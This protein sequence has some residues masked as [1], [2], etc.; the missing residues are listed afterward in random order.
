MKIIL[1]HLTKSKNMRT[2]YGVLLLF[3]IQIVSIQ[4]Q[5]KIDYREFTLDNGLHVILHKDNTTPIVSTVVLYH[6]GSKNENPERTGFAHFFE[7]LMFEGSENIPRG[8][9]FEIIESE[10]GTL[11]AYTSNDITLYYEV[12]PSNKLE[13]ALY[14][15]SERMLHLKVDTIGVNTQRDVI[16]EEMKQVMEEQPYMS[17]LRELPE[18]MYP[19]HPYQWPVIGAAEHLDASTL[20]E[21]MNFYKTY[22]V[23]NNAILCVAGDIDYDHAEKMVR[24]YFEEIPKGT[25]ELYRPNV[26]MQKPQEEIRDIVYDNIQLPALFQGYQMPP[27]THPDSYALNLLS[28]YL[29]GGKS[30]IMYKE[31]VDKQKKALQAVAFPMD[32]EQGGMFIVLCI[33]NMGIDINELS[34]EVDKIIAQVKQ[35]GIS[36]TDFQKLLNIQENNQV[37]SL[38]SI[39]GIAQ[40]LAN[41][42]VFYGSADYINKELEMY[43]KVTREDIKR[44]A[45]K[46]LTM[47][48]RV[49]L[50]YLPKAQ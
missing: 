36:D 22:Y 29:V 47:D 39:A 12:V 27:K 33:A 15:E 8:K 7:H 41:A 2:L 10:G 31:L 25:K 43:R 19:G 42:H 37:N 48:S 32:L 20:D 23:P 3:L 38:A 40:Q 6:V 1:T 9:Y 21:F 5:T 28:T 34:D 50:T 24:K 18:R 49:V 45:N 11:N 17:F 46:Y 14:M 4:G 44:V 13:L 16:K 30:S 26:K 35:E